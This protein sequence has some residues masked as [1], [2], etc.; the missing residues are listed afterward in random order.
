MRIVIEREVHKYQKLVWDF[1]MYLRDIWKYREL[2][3]DQ[4]ELIDEIW[5][6]WHYLKNEDGIEDEV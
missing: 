5:H 2:T 1:Q 3:D 6:E 4:A